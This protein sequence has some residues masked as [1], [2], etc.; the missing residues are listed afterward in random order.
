MRSRRAVD[1]AHRE[2]RPQR[3]RFPENIPG[4]AL[5]GLRGGGRQHREHAVLGRRHVVHRHQ[6][7]GR[8]HLG[9][10]EGLRV[11]LRTKN[12]LGHDFEQPLPRLQGAGH[13]ARGRRS[14]RERLRLGHRFPPRDTARRFL[15]G[16][17]RGTDPIRRN[18]EDRAHR[19]G[20]VLHTREKPL[21]LHVQKRGR[22]P[23]LLRRERKIAAETALEGAPAATRES[24]PTSAGA[25]FIPF[26]V[27]MRRTSGSTSPRLSARP[28]WRR[29]TA[30]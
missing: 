18:E 26:S 4:A 5:R 20:R 30:P 23:R 9:R 19:R 16:H 22:T 3:L 29:A 28:S 1:Q 12:R 11:Q 13:S 7:Q 27:V 15:Q 24:A 2:G 10:E 25:G 14:A 8:G 17:L 6:S 21:R